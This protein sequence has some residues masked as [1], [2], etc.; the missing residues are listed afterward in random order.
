MVKDLIEGTPPNWNQHLIENTF[1]PID[2][3]QIQQ[4]PITYKENEDSLMWPISDSGI[5]SVKSGY[6]ALQTWKNNL[7][8]GT[9][10]QGPMEQVWKKVWGIKTIPRHKSFLW[11]LLHNALLVR[12]ELH[13]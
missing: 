8:Q 13:K 12:D 11:R 1:L 4:I 7:V 5:Y 2:G 3:I 10:N 9:S 6:Q